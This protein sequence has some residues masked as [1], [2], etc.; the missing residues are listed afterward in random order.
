M[1]GEGKVRHPVM[2]VCGDFAA[3]GVEHLVDLVQEDSCEVISEKE[4]PGADFCNRFLCTW[5]V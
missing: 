2:N 3:K 4:E 1:S 5:A